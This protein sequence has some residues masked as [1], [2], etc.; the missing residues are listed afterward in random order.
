MPASQ[1]LG[2]SLYFARQLAER[3]NEIAISDAEGER[4]W[5]TLDRRVAAVA[6]LLLDQCELQPGDHVALLIGNRIEFIEAL[7]GSL[8][9][10]LWV[11]PINTH[12]AAAEVAYIVD[13]CGASM[14]FHD[15][16]LSP[17][18]AA[19]GCARLN[20]ETCDSALDNMPVEAPVT[21][22]SPA[23]GAMLYT[24]GTTGR[25]KGVKR[26]NP[27][28]V[29]EMIERFQ[30][31]GKVIGLCGEGVHLVTGPLYHA[32]PGLYAVYDMMSGARVVIMPR[33]DCARFFHWVEAHRI[34]TT[35]LVP[36]MFVRLLEHAE[37][38]RS[39]FD[40]DISSLRLVMH[41]AAPVS[42]EVKQRMIEWW[43]PILRE[44]WGSTEAGTIS[45]V[46]S[47]EWLSHPGT[48]GRALP[49]YE[50]YI[51]NELGEPIEDH[52]GLL[53][54]RHRSLAQAFSYHNDP[55]KTRETHP[56][57]FTF[58]IGDI[59]W[60][61]HEGYIYLSDR[62]S[63]MIISGGV[64]IYP[65]EV[66]QGLSAHPDVVDVAVFGMPDDEWGERVCAL[67]QLRPHVSR[68][69]EQAD[70]LA[71]FARGHMAAFKVPRSIQFIDEIP[72]TPTGKAV[73]RVLRDVWRH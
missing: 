42:R 22:A 45:I 50:V 56:Q 72:R 28:T 6:H 16:S 13:D 69:E 63:N 21:L 35:H 34:T 47:Q 53:F 44:Y 67:I 25:P 52:E 59:G 60:L 51:G 66:E 3:P 65:A 4:T 71:Q 26:A 68:S 70:A 12:L 36:T 18:L 48:V 73:V 41:G 23:G 32:A 57:P 27:A 55:E 15:R 39:G 5:T 29:K 33:W 19:T 62:K 20:I 30:T 64:N 43:G 14:V 58:C 49:H 31:L 10:G 61:D 8:L 7:L 37:Q 11:T 40:A 24:S 1:D 17:L 9:A 38:Q 2:L 54:S 46:D